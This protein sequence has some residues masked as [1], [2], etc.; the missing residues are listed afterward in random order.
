MSKKVS[1]TWEV[2]VKYKIYIKHAL[3]REEIF[4]PGH[5]NT[6]KEFS[7]LEILMCTRLKLYLTEFY[8]VGCLGFFSLLIPLVTGSN[9]LQKRFKWISGEGLMPNMEENHFFTVSSW[10]ETP[11]WTSCAPGCSVSSALLEKKMRVRGDTETLQLGLLER[12]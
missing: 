2:R 7:L 4:S 12:A 1:L 6:W 5:F 11:I 3:F 10:V 8:C 9:F